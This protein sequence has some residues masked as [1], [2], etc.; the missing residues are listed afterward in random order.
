MVCL[1]YLFVQWL[2]LR[3]PDHSNKQCQVMLHSKLDH[4]VITWYAGQIDLDTWP[5]KPSNHQEIN[6]TNPIFLSRIALNKY[7]CYSLL[8]YSQNW[9]LQADHVINLAK[10]DYET[11]RHHVPH[12]ENTP[13]TIKQMK[14]LLSQRWKAKQNFLFNHSHLRCIH[15][16]VEKEVAFHRHCHP[17]WHCKYWNWL[18]VLWHCCSWWSQQLLFRKL[19]VSLF[20]IAGIQRINV[21][22]FISHSFWAAQ[23]LSGTGAAIV[24]KY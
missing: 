12:L 5:L 18:Q 8:L 14:S 16:R 20:V 17:R 10:V 7:I 3:G 22:I 9:L 23:A 24:M 11:L 1:G 21:S 19:E 15:H 6:W 2:R 4:K 13:R